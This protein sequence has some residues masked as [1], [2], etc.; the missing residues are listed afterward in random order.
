MMHTGAVV[1]K[2]VAFQRGEIARHLTRLSAQDR[3]L[4]FGTYV[5]DAAVERYV[6][7][8]DFTRDR[9]F[10]IFEPDLTLSGVAHLALESDSGTAELG[11]S[12]D[13]AHRGR[14][15]GYALLNR[16]KLHAQNFGYKKLYMHCLAENQI[17]LHLARKAGMRVVTEY[18]EAD[19]H[20]ALSEAT[21]GDFAREFFGDQIAL[22]DY[23]LKRQVRWLPKPYR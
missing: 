6:R 7:S 19:A 1:Q 3:R 4:R 18:G 15:F 11:L 21:Y 10:G 12:V 22:I 14:G 20:V 23:L 2:L 5:S 13:S 9:V 8:I 16:G 17:M